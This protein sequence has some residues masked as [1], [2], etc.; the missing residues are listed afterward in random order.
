MEPG[1]VE[2]RIFNGMSRWLLQPTAVV[3]VWIGAQ[4]LGTI[5][6]Y[7]LTAIV[8]HHLATAHLAAAVQAELEQTP[9]APRPPPRRPPT[10]V[11]PAAQRAA[12]RVKRRARGG[13]R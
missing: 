5:S 1:A 7:A 10:T 11:I 9:I 4:L 8:Q 3:E 12:L 13:S 2:L 6:G